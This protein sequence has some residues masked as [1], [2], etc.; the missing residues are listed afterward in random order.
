MGSS[1]DQA[2]AKGRAVGGPEISLRLRRGRAVNAVAGFLQGHL[3]VPNVYL[4]P[5]SALWKNVDVVAADGAGSGD[6]H[7]AE[8]RFLP[9]PTHVSKAGQL[10]EEVKTLPAHYKYLAVNKNSVSLTLGDGP[11]TFSPDGIG[12]V[13]LLLIEET[14]DAL[15]RV[16]LVVRPERFR[17]EP[18]VAARVERFLERATPDMFVRV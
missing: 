17:L 11:L 2:I 18:K 10:I 16:E 14:Q 1:T 13:G 7:A 12:R 9:Y 5:R 3:R 4:E 8:V 15:L 6:I